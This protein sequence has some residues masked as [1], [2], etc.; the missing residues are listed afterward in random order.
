MMILMIIMMVPAVQAVKAVKVEKARLTQNVVA[1]ILPSSPAQAPL[2]EMLVLTSTER[3]TTVLAHVRK[4][5]RAASNANRRGVANPHGLAKHRPNHKP[6][7]ATVASMV[8]TA[9]LTKKVS[10]GPEFARQKRLV[11][12]ARKPRK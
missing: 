2:Q 7:L 6:P 1:P 10:C 3:P 9:L 12:F 11:W 5:K 8:R 4:K